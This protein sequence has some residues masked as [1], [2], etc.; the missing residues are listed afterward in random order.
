MTILRHRTAVFLL[1]VAALGGVWQLYLAVT[2]PGRL[3]PGLAEA[4]RRAPRVDVT[5]TLGFV[6]EDFHIRL[7]QNHGV[8][9]GVRG[10]TVLLNRV[11]PEDVR[12]IARY[13]W[14]QRIAAQGA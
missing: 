1:V 3:E 8:G 10:T 14:V 7:F 9:S 5:I 4:L 12:R 11:P 6:P 2:A 13:D